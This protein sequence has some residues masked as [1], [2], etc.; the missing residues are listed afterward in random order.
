MSRSLRGSAGYRAVLVLP[1]ARTPFA[2]ALLARLSY[3]VLPLPLLLALRDGTGS[4]T[5][6]GA[7]VGLFGL[8]SALLGPA[9]A[10]LV[11]RRP[12]ALA[13]LTVCYALLLAA[14]AA[15][16]AVGLSAWAAVLLAALA[17]VFPPPVGPLMR[18]LW[19]ELTT[20]EDQR[21]CALSLDTVA[22]STVFACGPVLGGLLA[23][24]TSAA[25]A[26]AA[27]ALLAA[28]GFTA[29]ARALRGRPAAGRPTENG[30][31]AVLGPLRA[32]GFV[33]LLAVVLAVAGV[34]SADELAVV[35]AWG[36]GAAGPL[37]ALFS[38]GGA[39]GALVYGR[40]AWRAS[41]GRRLLV[42][43]AAASACYGL[44]AVLFAPPGAAFGLFCAGACT[45][46]LLVTAYLLVEDLVPADSRTEAGAWVNTAYNLGGA[47]GSAAGGVLAERVAPAA[48]FTAAALALA[49]V[50][51]VV[52]LRRC[53]LR[54]PVA[55]PAVRTAS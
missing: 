32:P 53:S 13:A 30:G 23:A 41:A 54:R 47:L 34:L 11:A 37:L 12:G 2:A 7:A 50:T 51:A 26:L 35:A 16:A 38:V 36:A 6:A 25:W 9:R 27:C 43:A 15:S 39:A 17:G 18:T 44:P 33:P 48:V 19:G 1:H 31:R 40:L 21:R 29:F 10:R 24:R 28:A 46:A 20:G 52:A 22:E 55:V 4:F 5:A 8:L 45:D 42:L 14:L 3:G 49:A